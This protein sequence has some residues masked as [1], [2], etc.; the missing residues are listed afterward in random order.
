MG[1]TMRDKI[2]RNIPNA[3]TSLR[4]LSSLG[5]IGF[6]LTGALSPISLGIW[7][8]ATAGTD[9]VDG[10]LARSLHVTSDVGAFLD[11]AADKV[12]NIGMMLALLA[13][14][15]LP[16]WSLL[17][18][19]RDI[20]VAIAT[21]SHK[22]KTAKE[23][24]NQEGQLPVLNY[25]D[26]LN[27]TEEN[28]YLDGTK[29][30]RRQV[31]KK[32]FFDT[33][34]E[35]FQHLSKGENILPTMAGKLK[36]W[37]LVV[38]IASSLVL[39]SFLPLSLSSAIANFFYGATLVDSAIDMGLFY[40]KLKQSNQ[41]QKWLHER[42]LKI[43]EIKEEV[44]AEKEKIKEEVSVKESVRFSSSEFDDLIVPPEIPSSSKERGI[45]RQKTRFKY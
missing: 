24:A 17:V 22:S 14:G 31:K 9:F 19:V 40:R 35:K 28:G 11:G 33:L 39:P 15:T 45:A 37:L 5:L 36:M 10:K 21:I 6:T 44:K 13:T 27:F 8:L 25:Q 41:K 4:I 30:E 38:G 20:P 26:R 1:D 7:Y 12:L 23:R 3:I 16:V 18:L 42:S 2:R 32:I 43:E 29:K 34:Q